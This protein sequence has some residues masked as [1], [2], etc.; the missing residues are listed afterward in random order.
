MLFKY[1]LNI[2][3]NYSNLSTFVI[4]FKLFKFINRLKLN[5]LKLYQVV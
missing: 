2:F 3:Q 4:Q 5:H 1:K